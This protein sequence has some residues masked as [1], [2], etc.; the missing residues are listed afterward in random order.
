[1]IEIVKGKPEYMS[2]I[3]TV[4]NHWKDLGDGK[5]GSEAKMYNTTSKPKAAELVDVN[6]DKFHTYGIL[7]SKTEMQCFVDGKSY[8]TF[9]EHIPTNP[10]DM[11]MMLTLEFKKNA[12]DREQGDGRIEGPCVS[13]DENLREMSR[14]LVDF[15]RIYR[16]VPDKK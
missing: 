6:D 14:V 9:K 10:V 1:M 15:V 4:A 8:Y 11:F 3:F 7:W 16:Q 13:D 5:P 12:W 2:S